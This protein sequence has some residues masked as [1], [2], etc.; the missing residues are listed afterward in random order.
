MNLNRR[1]LIWAISIGGLVGILLA[2]AI[3]FIKFSI[4][5][6]FP[7]GTTVAGIDISYLSQEDAIK[8]LS[9]KEDSY[10]NTPLTL[11]LT[12]KTW[13]ITPA[14]MGVDLLVKETLGGLLGMNAKEIG[15]L[16]LF[17]P[18]NDGGKELS[19]IV[20]IDHEK[21]AAAIDKAFNLQEIKPKS[22]TFYFEGN[23]LAIQDGQDGTSIHYEKLAEDLKASA[24]NLQNNNIDIIALESGP[25]VTKE[26]LESQKEEIEASLKYT[27][28]LLD[29]IYSDD[30]YLKLSDH[31][32]WVR[33]VE[34]QKVSLPYLE[35]N[36]TVDPIE[37]T[38][39]ETVVA[40]EIDQKKLD[41]YVDAEISKWLDRPAEPV[42]IYTD[43]DGKVIIEG[44]GNDGRKIQRR[45]LKESIELAVANKIPEITIPVIKIE[46][47]FDI[48]ADLQEKG[49]KE[50]LA[51]GHTTYYGSPANRVHNIK[52]GAAKFNGLLIA[53][54]EVF[55]FNENLGPVDGS[56]GYKKELVIKQEGTI[57]EYGGGICQ[58]STTAYRAALFAGLQIVERNQH[59][60]AVSYYS[61]VLGH[62]LD[63]TIYLGGADLKFKN[64]TGNHILI[65]TYVENDYELNFVFYG[66]ADGRSVEMEGPYLSNYVSPGATIYKETTDLLT[67]ETK[68]VEKSHVGFSALWYRHLKLADGTETKETIS[69]RYKAIPAK[70]LVGTGT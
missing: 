39:G 10:L 5:G 48:A 31:L 29:P 63:A 18:N 8:A 16:D 54:D 20:S 69:T 47:E 27:V 7:P 62:G 4:H 6:K 26:M 65:Q 15:I 23:K 32:D 1:K 66:T 35:T 68:Q 51:V 59:S 58:V 41:E 12:D 49:I 11:S 28:A 3:A 30:W 67:G 40:I 60:Y 22:A 53:P 36:F 57:P 21:L 64:D 46:P 61:Q 55:S 17:L 50:R 2:A 25:V 56:T 43:Q 33:F 45:L 38:A 19:L 42:K 24:G 14:E 34:K 44:K 9:A 70:I 37:G 52:T 13:T